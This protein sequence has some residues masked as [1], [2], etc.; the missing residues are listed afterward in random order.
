M[1]LKKS[2][3]LLGAK[4]RVC[5][6]FCENKYLGRNVTRSKHNHRKNVGATS[7]MVGMVAIGLRHLKF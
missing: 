3:I 7:A 1:I 4:M 6:I 2:Q 5:V